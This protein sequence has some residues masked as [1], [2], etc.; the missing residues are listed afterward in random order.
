MRTAL[1][2]TLVTG[3][4]VSVV[5]L[6]LRKPTI[7]IREVIKEVPKEVVRE[8]VKEVPKEVVR[9]VVKEVPREVIRV[10][11]KEVPKEILVEAKLTESQTKALAIGAQVLNGKAWSVRCPLAPGSSAPSVCT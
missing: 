5:F 4:A 2:W 10:V 9:E 7:V 3:L 11:V 6:V 8:V 1:P